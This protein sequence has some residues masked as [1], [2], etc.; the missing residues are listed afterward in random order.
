M[1]P[2]AHLLV[3]WREFTALFHMKDVGA[4][5]ALSILVPQSMNWT[6]SV[7]HRRLRKFLCMA[8]YPP[9]VRL[10]LIALPWGLTAA[11]PAGP[12]P[13]W[14]PWLSIV[15][16]RRAKQPP[17]SDFSREAFFGAGLRLL[18][19]VGCD[20]RWLPCE[21]PDSVTQNACALPLFWETAHPV[22]SFAVTPAHP[23]LCLSDQEDGQ[24]WLGQPNWKLLQLKP[25]YL[26]L[27]RQI[28]SSWLYMPLKQ[29]SSVLFR[30][31]KYTC[32]TLYIMTTSSL[33]WFVSKRI[34]C[35][36]HAVPKR[37]SHILY[38]WGT[39][40]HNTFPASFTGQ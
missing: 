1:T 16:R 39:S 23:F 24:H 35:T 21:R 40:T 32:C 30:L 20:E 3:K 11:S 14:P 13:C 28:G 2:E 5:W 17:A 12:P 10:T 38:S 4:E 6:D 33:F 22:P 15:V 31:S 9:I 7:F 19:E 34:F 29:A 37:L 26:D 8:P 25:K 27:F 36:L 18:C